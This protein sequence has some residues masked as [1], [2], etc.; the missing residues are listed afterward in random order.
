[1][2][3]RKF[4]EL[5]DS[6]SAEQRAESKALTEALLTEMTLDELRRDLDI[7]QEDLAGILGIQQA[8]VS[9]QFRRPDW[10]IST[11]R[12]YIEAFGGKL[13][14]VARF[15]D[16]TVRLLQEEEKGPTAAA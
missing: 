9:K 2:M 16:R 1:M 11:L 15:P 14:L 4:K 13:E 3:A 8:A 5:R 10:H 7:A 12:K 6:M